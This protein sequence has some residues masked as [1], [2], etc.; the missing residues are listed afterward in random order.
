MITRREFLGG[1][2]AGVALSAGGF[3]LVLVGKEAAAKSAGPVL[4]SNIYAQFIECAINE[5]INK[6]IIMIDG[7]PAEILDYTY[8]ADLSIVVPSGYDPSK[9]FIGDRSLFDIF[10]IDNGIHQLSWVMRDG[11]TEIIKIKGLDLTP[12]GNVIPFIV[13]KRQMVF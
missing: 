13:C 8:Y 6:R 12:Y 10:A 3:P 9:T 11:D 2:I 4:R 5:Q 1:A 7:K